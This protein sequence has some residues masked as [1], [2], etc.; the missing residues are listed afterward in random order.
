MG[1][2]SSVFVATFGLSCML[3]VPNRVAAAC[4]DDPG[5]AAS[6]SAA[7]DAI[8]SQCNCA[9]G[10]S[11][12]TYVKCASGVVRAARNAGTLSRSCATVVLKCAMQ[13]TIGEPD[14][15][16]CCSTTSRGVTRGRI[17]RNAASCRAPAGGHA[18]VAYALSVCDACT[19]T[20]C[21]VPPS[22]TPTPTPTETPVVCPQPQIT[23]P[24]NLIA[25][26]LTL[27]NG[28]ADCGVPGSVSPAPPFSGEVD[29]VQGATLADLG[30][31]CM[32]AGTLPAIAIP[33]GSTAM[34][35]VVGMSGNAFVLGPGGTS[36]NNCTRGA[37]PGVHCI[38][39]APGTD[40]YGACNSDVDC[41]MG[42]LATGACAPDA[43]CFFGPPIALSGMCVVNT[44]ASDICGTADL[45]GNTSL[46]ATIAAR[47]YINKSASG[48]TCPQCLNG[49]CD[50]GADAG[51]PCTAVGP[52][53]TAVEC[54]P[55]PTD[56]FASLTV[57]LY[58]LTTA[59][60][61]LTETAGHFCPVGPPPPTPT[62][63]PVCPPTPTPLGANAFGL[64]G[65][66][67]IQ[68]VGTGLVS[69]NLLHVTVGATFCIQKTGNT[70]I[71]S[72]AKLPV[73][74]AISAAGELDLTGA[75]PL[76]GGPL[77]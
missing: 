55:A 4:G 72:F 56:Y 27:Q 53:N 8:A 45:S 3:F 35:S 25:V 36:A 59:T 28:S 15:V 73:P 10:F 48:T 21:V 16:P 46:A 13:S 57:P 41:Q 6:V 29:D 60:S 61:T 54:A 74:G 17:A 26:P 63:P 38:N 71:D 9:A 1:R 23:L 70:L 12:G 19:A 47:I 37:G 34:M 2:I 58:P 18:C 14:A 50:S 40:G 24:P 31:G 32:Y 51:A 39:G 7:R 11:H 66:S 49:T 33:G 5:D 20:G 44:L 62:R 52:G 75:I 69:S 68:E 43:N 42:G 64:H 76:L 77:P 67:A 22:A 65:A 30:L